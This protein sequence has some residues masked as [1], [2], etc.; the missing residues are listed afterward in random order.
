M[1]REA[2]FVHAVEP[3]RQTLEEHFMQTLSRDGQAAS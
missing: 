1:S 3:R 2:V